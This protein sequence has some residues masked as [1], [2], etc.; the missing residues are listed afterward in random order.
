MGRFEKNKKQIIEDETQICF[1]VYFKPNE[2]REVG[3]KQED[4]ISECEFIVYDNRA[5]KAKLQRQ[6]MALENF[7]SGND[8]IFD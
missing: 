1:S 2:R 6:E 4:I 8:I 5:E 7:Y 3:K